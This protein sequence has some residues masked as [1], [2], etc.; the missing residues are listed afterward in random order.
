MTPMATTSLNPKG[1]SEV[2]KAVHI[3][4]ARKHPPNI[5][6]IE[7]QRI[8]P[9]KPLS[10][11]QRQFVKCLAEGDSVPNALVRAGYAPGSPSIGY[12]LL[13][14]PNVQK[15][16]AKYQAEYREAAAISK[17]DVMDMLKE[18]YEMAKLMSEPSTMVSAAREIGKMCGYYEPKKVQL[19]V[20]LNGATKFAE[21]SDAELFAMIEKNVAEAEA[22]EQAEKEEHVL[23]LEAPEEQTPEEALE[24][25]LED[26]E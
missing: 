7:A 25:A 17:K 6:G 21:L 5:R 14:R 20:T 1:R 26:E 9:D 2:K 11:L 22:A 13:E 18:S 3:S 15:L 19:D 4:A 8:S 23:S 12:R 24:R 16:L 10:N